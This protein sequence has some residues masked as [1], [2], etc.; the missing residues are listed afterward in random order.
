MTCYAC[1]GPEDQYGCGNRACPSYVPRAQR[2][3]NYGVSPHAAH[4]FRD[5]SPVPEDGVAILSREVAT[6]REALIRMTT[7]IDLL[8]R[9]L[10]A[11]SAEV[12]R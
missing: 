6:L 10:L 8:E 3:L 9:G 7:R 2:P 4:P 1:G 11:V 5:P 12:R